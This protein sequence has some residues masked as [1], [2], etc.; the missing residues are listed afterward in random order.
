MRIE[1]AKKF[2]NESGVNS[3]NDP[4]QLETSSFATERFAGIFKKLI[5]SNDKVLDLGCN[6]GRFSFF[7]EEKFNAKVIGID[8]AE[9]VI[10]YAN[11]VAEVKNSKCKFIIGD[12]NKLPF[13]KNLFDVAIFPNNLVECSYK[14]F[15]NLCKEIKKVLKYKGK[16][17]I[18]Y[19]IPK[20][21][22]F[23]KIDKIKIL[24]KGIFNYPT[25]YYDIKSI[26]KILSKFFVIIDFEILKYKNRFGKNIENAC[27]IVQKVN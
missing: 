17:F 27:F 8:C 5:K 2:Y 15:K 21:F 20:L 19:N 14:E 26:K 25:Y 7:C 1:I 11:K 23:N 3:I 18:S 9:K 12:Y 6:C 10:D 13:K 22:H 16:F 4:L 24:D